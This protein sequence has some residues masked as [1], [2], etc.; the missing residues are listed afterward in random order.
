MSSQNQLCFQLGKWGLRFI[1]LLNPFWF[2]QLLGL[3]TFGDL[4]PHSEI[5]ILKDMLQHHVLLS[6][7]TTCSKNDVISSLQKHYCS[8]LLGLAEIPFQ[9]N[10]FSSKWSRSVETY[11]TSDYYRY[12]QNHMTNICFL[13]PMRESTHLIYT[14]CMKTQWSNFFQEGVNGYMW[15][16]TF[17]CRYQVSSSLGLETFQITCFHAHEKSRL[18]RTIGRLQNQRYIPI[19]FCMF[20]NISNCVVTN[21]LICDIAITGV[22]S[23]FDWEEPKMEK[24]YD[25]GLVTSL[26]WRNNWF[27]KVRFRYNQFEKTQ[28]GQITQVQVTKIED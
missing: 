22:V 26:K 21:S 5:Y 27:F 1:L 23:N 6:L 2:L 11:L 8:F 16:V 19:V 13:V 24:S 4:C 17:S 10:V 18:W 25:V 9:F 3:F 15:S 7:D 12:T 14:N 28:F 20:Y